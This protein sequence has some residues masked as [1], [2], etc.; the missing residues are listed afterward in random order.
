MTRDFENA[1]ILEI[2]T[3]EMV[4]TTPNFD[5]ERGSAFS[6]LNRE[7]VEVWEYKSSVNKDQAA[8]TETCV[9]LK[10]PA[11]EVS[12]ADEVSRPRKGKREKKEE[13]E[14]GRE[15]WTKLRNEKTKFRRKA[16]VDSPRY[17]VASCKLP[18]NR[19]T[20]KI[21]GAVSLVRFVL[22]SIDRHFF[23]VPILFFRSFHGLSWSLQSSGEPLGEVNRIF[24]RKSYI[25]E[26]LLYFINRHTTHVSVWLRYDSEIDIDERI[27]NVMQII[28]R[29][30]CEMFYFNI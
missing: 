11:D 24:C 5:G 9:H 16:W 29:H 1:E 14:R 27:L 22:I 25:P 28:G 18:R 6:S 15:W 3:L 23:S 2:F 21:P 13:G 20:Y 30:W 8:S 7:R 10:F 4:S 26:I 19:Q 17:I 12:T